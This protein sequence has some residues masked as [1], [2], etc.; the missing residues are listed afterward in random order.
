MGARGR[1]M[2]VADYSWASVARRYAESLHHKAI[3]RAE[4]P[5]FEIPQPLSL[6]A[7]VAA[8]RDW[9][10]RSRL[11]APLVVYSLFAA[12]VYW[13]Q[14]PEPPLSIDHISYFKLADEIRAEFNRGDYWRSFNS[15]RGYGVLLAYLY[16]ATGSHVT[17]P[18][19]GARRDDRGLPVGVPG[20]HGPV[21]PDARAGDAVRGAWR[22]LFVSF[23]A[24]IWGMTDFSASL[25]RTVIMPF[26]VLLVWFFFRNYGVALALRSAPALILLSLLHLSSAP[27]LPR[28]S[29]RSSSSTT[30]CAGASASTRDVA[31]FIGA[32]VAPCVLQG[33]IEEAPGSGAGGFVRYTLQMTLVPSA[34]GDAAQPRGGTRR[35]GHDQA[36]GG[37]EHAARRRPRARSPSPAG[38]GPPEGFTALP[39]VGGGGVGSSRR[40]R[41][42]G[43]EHR[44]PTSPRGG[45][46]REA[47]VEPRCVGRSSCSPSRGATSRRPSRRRHDRELL[48]PHPRAR[49]LGRRARPS[50]RARRGPAR[51]RHDRRSPWA[52]LVAAFGLQ[53]TV[54]WAAARPHPIFR[55]TSRRS[56]RSTW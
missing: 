28:V 29:A 54:M 56:A 45:R 46:H 37:H 33:L 49:R 43:V 35:A 6:P 23:G 24:S 1:D 17:E 31:P 12:I 44:E 10:D 22:A 50:G 38:R 2:A 48:R 55:S 27:C 42:V 8:L 18:Q 51:P 4:Q 34:G 15:V 14:G 30:R 53:A 7:P 36:A 47:H 13:L 25:N 20:P 16:D 19:G 3:V 5:R 21:H 11:V 32:V 52:S 41:P 40:E 39:T 9:I 26:V